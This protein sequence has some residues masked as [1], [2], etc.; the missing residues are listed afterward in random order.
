MFIFESSF[1]FANVFW[2]F[3]G[4]ILADKY[5]VKNLYLLNSILTTIGLIILWYGAFIGNVYVMLVGNIIS[6]LGGMA[7][8]LL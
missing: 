2:P 4:G 6:G 3:I 8:N 1:S 7:L 5:G